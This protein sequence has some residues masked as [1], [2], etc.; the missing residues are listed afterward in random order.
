ML[1]SFR[2]VKLGTDRRGSP[3]SPVV[4]LK[5]SVLLRFLKPKLEHRAGLARNQW[6]PSAGEQS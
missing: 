6:L 3:L 2:P 4:L 1:V 5:P